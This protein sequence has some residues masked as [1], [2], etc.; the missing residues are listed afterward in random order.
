MQCPLFI[1]GQDILAQILTTTQTIDFAS[2]RP[3]GHRGLVGLLPKTNDLGISIDSLLNILILL[4]PSP[5]QSPNKLSKP[6]R[7]NHPHH[8]YSPTPLISLSPKSYLLDRVKNFFGSSENQN[9]LPPPS[10]SQN[11]KKLLGLRFDTTEPGVIELSSSSALSSSSTMI[12][13]HPTYL[14]SFLHFPRS[15][16]LL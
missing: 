10:K 3:L 2:P 13:T 9:N 11:R 6:F 5:W 7:H 1:N 14:F 8:H 12:S 16:P 4:S 15:L